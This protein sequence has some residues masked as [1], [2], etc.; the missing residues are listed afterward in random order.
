MDRSAD[1]IDI[2]VEYLYTREPIQ[3]TPGLA[4]QLYAAAKR[5]GIIE[6][7]EHV[8]EFCRS[9]HETFLESDMF[10]NTS[11]CVADVE[12]FVE[13]LESFSLNAA[14][15]TILMQRVQQ[16]SIG[17]SEKIETASKIIYKIVSQLADPTLRP[18]STSN[19]WQTLLALKRY[20]FSGNT[21]RCVLLSLKDKIWNNN[22]SSSQTLS[23]SAA[24]PDDHSSIPSNQEDFKC[25]TIEGYYCCRSVIINNRSYCLSKNEINVYSID[26]NYLIS[27][28]EYTSDCGNIVNM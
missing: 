14:N 25:E 12:M 28:I 24:T 3:V 19:S 7:T 23:D 26:S 9:N 27:T 5:F 1:I 2:V 22:F 6:M 11:N 10:W 16:W 4:I 20:S 17:D 8:K 18:E 21:T 15:K 13:F